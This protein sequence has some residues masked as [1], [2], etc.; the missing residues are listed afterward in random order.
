[1][2]REGGPLEWFN[3][4]FDFDDP[5]RNVGTLADWEERARAKWQREVMSLPHAQEITTVAQ[6]E[7]K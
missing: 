3:P 1:M 6:Q 5:I 2:F 7:V 4:P